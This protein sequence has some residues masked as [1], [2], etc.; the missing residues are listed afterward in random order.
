MTAAK[1]LCDCFAVIRIPALSQA[2]FHTMKVSSDFSQLSSCFR[3]IKKTFQFKWDSELDSESIAAGFF[4]IHKFIGIF[5]SYQ[6]EQWAMP[7]LSL[8]CSSTAKGIVNTFANSLCLFTGRV[9]K[10]LS[11]IKALSAHTP[12]NLEFRMQY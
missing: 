3:D 12:D 11:V 9:S 2:V 10:W 5:F 1:K 8:L 6:T 4:A 7:R